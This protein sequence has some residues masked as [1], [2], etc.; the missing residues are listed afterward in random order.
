[1]MGLAHPLTNKLEIHNCWLVSTSRHWSKNYANRAKADVVKVYIEWAV[2][3]EYAV[4]DVNI[5]KYLTTESVR[6]S[7]VAR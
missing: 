7:S 6:A 4:I 3:K 5:P 2:G 1:M